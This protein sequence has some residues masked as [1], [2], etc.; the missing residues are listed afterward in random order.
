MQ[1]ASE[2]LHTAK[3]PKSGAMRLKSTEA[4][5]KDSPSMLEGARKV[6]RLLYASN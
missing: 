5:L 2:F 3:F 1:K 6:H 4:Q